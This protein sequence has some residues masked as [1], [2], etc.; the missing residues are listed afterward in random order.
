MFPHTPVDAGVFSALDRVEDRRKGR[1]VEAWGHRAAVDLDKLGVLALQLVP[2]W[3]GGTS[4][5]IH[6]VAIHTV[7]SSQKAV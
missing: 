5:V 6:K 1:Q 3:T 2:A 7:V 4:R